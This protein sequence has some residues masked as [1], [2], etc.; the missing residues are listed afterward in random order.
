MIARNFPQVGPFSRLRKLSLILV[1]LAVLTACASA[2]LQPDGESAWLAAFDKSLQVAARDYDLSGVVVIAKDDTRILEQSFGWADR[3]NAVPNA[4]NTRFNIASMNKMFTALMVL[5]LVEQGRLRLDEPII[6]WLPDYPNRAVAERVTIRQ[7]LSHT[8]GMGN[9]WEA[10]ATRNPASVCTT[11]DY[12]KLFVDDPLQHEP[13]ATFAYSNSGY[14]VLGHLLETVTGEDY[15]AYA[16][17]TLFAPL[18]MNDT[19]GLPLDQVVPRR[20]TG[21]TRSGLQAG[22]WQNN[23]YVNTFCGT[24]AGGGYSSANDLRRF[25]QALA[26]GTLLSPQ[27]MQQYTTGTQPYAKGR[28]GLGISEEQILG[29]RVIGHSGGHIGIAGELLVFPDDG[30]VAVILTNGDVDAFWYVRNNLMRHLIGDDEAGRPYWQTLDVIA[31]AEKDGLQAGL[32]AADQLGDT[33]RLREAV[34]DVTAGKWFHRGD[35]DRAIALFQLNAALFPESDEAQ[36]RLAEGARILGHTAIAIDA[37][38]RYLKRM[39]E[40]AEAKNNLRMLE[41]R[42]NKGT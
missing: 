19:G 17:R 33:S 18:G 37:Y 5:R 38:Q 27:L 9:F 32:A 22:T 31:R 2:R 23:A 34:I 26:A 4:L 21:H 13:G 41:S 16:K 7:L 6:R 39:P 40:D 36:R 11:A 1:V 29:H 12:L 15:D 35:A 24:A 28:Y 3:A 42:L 8:S 25:G 14:I 30:Y 10:L 20:A